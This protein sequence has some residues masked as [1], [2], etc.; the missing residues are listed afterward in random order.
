MVFC[1]G[2]CSG[3]PGKGGWGAIVVTPDGHVR[4]LGHGEAHTTNNA[5][6]LSG[7]LRALEFIGSRPEAVDVYTDSVYVIRGITQWVWGWRNRGWKTA[8]GN[9][10][11]NRELWQSLSGAVAR[12]KSIAPVNWHFVRGHAGIPGNERCDEIAVSY[13]KGRRADLYDGPLLQYGVAIHD[14]PDDTS[15]PEM[16]PKEEKK[17]AA[18][19]YL[20][21]VDGKARR[22]ATWKECEAAVKGRSGAKFKKATSEA[23]ERTILAAWGLSPKDVS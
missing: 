5:M 19:S 2:A 8:E 14:I 22:H 9:D 21:V 23:D 11:A 15:L 17:K 12:R 20:S 13:T 18:F 16:K 10:V 4:E 3:N 1:D 7:A 6:E